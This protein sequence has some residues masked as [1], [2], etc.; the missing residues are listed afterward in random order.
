MSIVTTGRRIQIRHKKL[1]DAIDDYAWQSD[2]ELARLDAAVPLQMPYQRYV[3]EY[4]FELSYPSTKR[5]EFAVDTLDGKHIGNC[6]YYNLSPSKSQAEMGIMV[7]NRDYWNQG[8]GSEIV[9][10][11]LDYIFNNIKLDKIYL[12]TLTWNIRAQKCFKKCGFKEAGLIERDHHTFLLMSICLEEWE[13]L[14]GQ[15]TGVKP[16]AVSIEPFVRRC[17]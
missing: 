15:S 1:S 5:Y 4:N 7:G 14:H 11:L 9:N 13:K 3:S 16:N 17:D 10:S 8:Y 12:T 6:V 2:A